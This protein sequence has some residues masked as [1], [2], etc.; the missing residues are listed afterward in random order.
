[1]SDDEFFEYCLN[2]A[3]KQ[4]RVQKKGTLKRKDPEDPDSAYAEDI[5]Y[6]AVL[7]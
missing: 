4:G 3:V 6:H 1:M 2:L 5:T 7:N